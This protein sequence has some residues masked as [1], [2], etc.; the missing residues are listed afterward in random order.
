[1]RSAPPDANRLLLADREETLIERQLRAL[2]VSARGLLGQALPPIDVRSAIDA[3]DTT[4]LAEVARVTHAEL[5]RCR[6]GS[7][8]LTALAGLAVRCADVR[9]AVTSHR[10]ERRCRALTGVGSAT[11]RLGR[12]A[13]AGELIGAVCGEVVDSCGF[14]R[15]LLSRV[16]GSTWSPWMAH[17]AHREVSDSDRQWIDGTRIPLQ[18]M[19]LEQQV[20]ADR[21]PA[22]VSG[23]TSDSQPLARFVAE[24]GTHAYVVAPIV[25]GG[26]VVGFLH[27]DYYPLGRTVDAIDAMVLGEFADA[28]GRIYERLVLLDRLR[29]Q[30]D[31]V[32]GAL[33]AAEAS[34]DDLVD[35]ELE[36]VRG[37]DSR[38]DAGTAAVLSAPAQLPD[39][40]ELL[41]PRE[42]EV[43]SLLVS[44]LSN[45]AIAER[46]VISDATVKSHV[47]QILRKLGAAN[48]SEVIAQYIGMSL[49]L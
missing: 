28:F 3:A 38:L 17:F 31:Q 40:D 36:L 39:V 11:S 1:M 37:T 16:S 20:L 42:R 13:S 44:G 12:L 5:R 18:T 15:A 21:R 48:R 9:R 7:E 35:S 24:T 47:K 46:L 14:N 49:E 43:V 6:P 34:M 29:V 25:P 27:A 26:E 23:R 45:A 4:W 22:F 10:V 30:R 8:Q 33:R 32:R 41:T 2:E 19:G